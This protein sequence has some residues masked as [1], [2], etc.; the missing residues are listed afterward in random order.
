MFICISDKCIYQVFGWQNPGKKLA[1]FI[2]IEY[3]ST[4]W[5]GSA[6]LEVYMFKLEELTYSI[7]LLYFLLNKIFEKFVL[8]F[9]IS[10]VNDIYIIFFI[11]SHVLLVMHVVC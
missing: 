11:A 2:I 3:S 8:E 6:A 5:T 10:L 1:N 9:S 7:P 4:F